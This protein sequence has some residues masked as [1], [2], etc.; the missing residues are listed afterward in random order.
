MCT[1]KYEQP[2]ASNMGSLCTH[3]TNYSINKD[4]D[5]FVQPEDVHDD[6]SHKRTVTSLRVRGRG[7]PSPSPNPYPSPILA[8]TPTL[9]LTLTLTR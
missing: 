7:S 8:L 2:T 3:L 4:S 5:A 6:S 1:E 9:T